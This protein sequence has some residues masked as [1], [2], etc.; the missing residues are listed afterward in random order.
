[1]EERERSPEKH[2]RGEGPPGKQWRRERGLLISAGGERDLLAM[3][4]R[5]RS[6]DKHSRGEGPPGKQWR[7]ER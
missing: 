6:P 2:W 1:M 4:E 5:E 3:E 7:R